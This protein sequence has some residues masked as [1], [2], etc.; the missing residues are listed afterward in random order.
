MSFT[1]FQYYHISD[2]G[3]KIEHRSRLG[4]YCWF[5]ENSLN[6]A[7]YYSLPNVSKQ[8]NSTVV[9]YC[10]HRRKPSLLFCL[11][12]PLVTY[13]LKSISF[14]FLTLVF[15]IVCKHSSILFNS[16]IIPTGLQNSQRKTNVFLFLIVSSNILSFR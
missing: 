15:E 1:S 9:Q 16:S 3:E 2:V 13:E 10:K 11:F 4:K 7:Q 14:D 5:E 12:T 6:N 8:W